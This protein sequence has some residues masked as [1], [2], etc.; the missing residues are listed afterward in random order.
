MTQSVPCLGSVDHIRLRA[1][2]LHS[3]ICGGGIGLQGCLGRRFHV[4]SDPGT[5]HCTR[6]RGG[7]SRTVL[8]R[9]DDML[10]GQP[11]RRECEEQRSE[12][13][14]A[15]HCCRLEL[16][17]QRLIWLCSAIGTRPNDDLG[18]N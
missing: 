14:R 15:E 9:G 7:S 16:P 11:A 6:A 10:A 12:P 13:D 8:F 2:R 1:D 17:E 3:T 5:T 18:R 4:F